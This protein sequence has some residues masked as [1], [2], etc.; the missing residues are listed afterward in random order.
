MGI[1]CRPLWA[2]SSQL[3]SEWQEEVSEKKV[4]VMSEGYVGGGG[5]VSHGPKGAGE[6]RARSHQTGYVSCIVGQFQ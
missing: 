3:S 5:G 6:G 4:G 2:N 1:Q